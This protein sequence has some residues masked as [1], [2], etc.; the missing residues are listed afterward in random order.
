MGGLIHK[1]V[2]DNGKFW[3]TVGT[4]NNILLLLSSSSSF[5]NNNRKTV[6]N[7]EELA[8]IFNKHFSKH[9]ETLHVEKTLAKNIVSSNITDPL[10]LKLCF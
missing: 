10:M 7:N 4:I 9:V 5:W 6:S 3:K 2:S 1:V 8:E